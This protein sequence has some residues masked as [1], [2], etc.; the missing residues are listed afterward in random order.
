M[1][2]GFYP[3]SFDPMTNG[4]LDIALQALRLCDRLIVAIGRHASKS[5][6]L[7][8]ESRSE[9]VRQALLE[10]GVDAERFDVQAFEGLAVEAAAN[11]G[12][13]VLV[14]GLRDA[15]DLPY[16]MQMAGMNAAMAPDLQTVFLPARP[17]NGHITATLVR[18]IH[19]MG[20]DVK[21]FVPL[22]VWKHLQSAA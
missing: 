20:G 12:A 18:Q 3:G 19:T 21:P 11:A 16:E 22:N 15:G 5:G 1:S 6:S 13:D 17:G 9:L 10:N 7:D 14:R 4:H 2:V 8:F